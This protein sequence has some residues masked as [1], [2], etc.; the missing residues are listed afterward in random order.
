MKKFLLLIILVSSL[1][2]RGQVTDCNGIVNGT[3]LMDT[4]GVCQQ[5][6][7]Y[8][9]ITHQVTFVDDANILVPGV[10]YD[11]SSEMVVFPD[12]PSNP[13]WND[14][15]STTTSITVISPIKE[16]RLLKIVDVLG[17]NAK[18]NSNTLLFFIFDD[19][20][21]ERRYIVE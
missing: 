9:F 2:I 19:G 13:Y 3:A 12:D 21:I 11:P 18:A 17:R 15:D 8:D 6:Y 16:R 20:K 4:C 7:L 10:D 1:Q 5:A 14:C